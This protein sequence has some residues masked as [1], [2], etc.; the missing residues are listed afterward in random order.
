MALLLSLVFN[1]A[2]PAMA[3]LNKDLFY[4]SKVGRYTNLFDKTLTGLHTRGLF[5]G[6]WKLHAHTRTCAHFCPLRTGINR[7][8]KYLARINAVDSE[9]FQ[10]GK[11][12]ETVDHIWF[13]CPCWRNLRIEIRQLA[14]ARMAR[15][16]ICARRMVRDWKR[17]YFRYMGTG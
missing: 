5:D 8:N 3:T 14:G 6:K 1:R 17:R 2:R 9:N 13:R 12:E 7:L 15:H 16:I 11:G 10:C 4:T